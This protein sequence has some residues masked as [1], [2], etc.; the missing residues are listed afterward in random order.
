LDGPAGR[1]P[2]DLV[3]P[4]R[5]EQ[6]HLAHMSNEGGKLLD[7]APESVQRVRPPVDGVR[8]FHVN[9]LRPT[10][11]MPRI[12]SYGRIDASRLIHGAVTRRATVDERS[13]GC[14]EHGPRRRAVFQ[15]A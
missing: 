1:S 13:A 4:P 14:G 12:A 11:G 9:P 5:S 3:R 7:L 15:L 6:A 8:H 2:R 10:E